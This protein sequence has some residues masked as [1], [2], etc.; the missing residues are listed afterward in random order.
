MKKIIIAML[1]VVMLLASCSKGPETASYIPDNALVV[2]N[3]NAKQL[4][5]KVD[6]KNLDDIKFVKMAREELRNENANLSAFVDDIIADPTST[7]LDLRED[8]II[9]LTEDG[10]SALIAAMHKQSKF[11]NFLQEL[12]TKNGFSCDIDKGNDYTSAKI[13]E[14][15]VSFNGEVAVIPLNF[16][17]SS[18]LDKELFTLEKEKSLANNKNFSEHWKTHTEIGFWMDMNNMFT[19]AEEL[20]GKDV[21]TNTGLPDDFIDEL[22]KGSYS[23]NLVFDKGA[24]RLVAKTQ[25]ISNKLMEKYMKDFN[26][27]LIDYMP[28]K[29]YATYSYAADMEA[30]ATMLE[31]SGEIDMNEPLVGDKNAKEILSAFGGSMLFSLFDITN[32]EDGIMPM[33]A[34]AA[35]IKD[36]ATVSKALEFFGLEKEGDMFIIPD[37]G[38]GKIMVCMNDKV[39]YLTNSQDAANHFANG[40]TN[41]MKGIASKVKKGNYFYADLNLSHYPSCLTSLIPVNIAQLL[42]QY[43][44]YT[45]GMTVNETTADWTIYLANKKENSLLATMHFVDDNMSELGNLADALVGMDDFDTTDEEYFV[46]ED[47]EEE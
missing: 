39:L 1:G 25:G 38:I 6:A 27:K 10:S 13:E 20:G 30:L 8:M 23:C 40:Y 2:A 37:L 29:C 44:D 24:I 21:L 14:I 11:E 18:D 35:D 19:L 16:L 17:T 43:L 4:L 46:E 32:S 33:M 47:Y 22:R 7:G 41:S 34:L 9:F 3:I 5:D 12:A 31:S 28:E 42:T 36:D 26:N 15:A 45:E